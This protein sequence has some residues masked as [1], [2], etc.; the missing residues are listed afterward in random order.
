MEIGQ[1]LRAT[2]EETVD[3]RTGDVTFD[4]PVTGEVEAGR[5]S[6]TLYLRG[7]L[8][9]TAP[10]VC[11]RCLGGF[12]QTLAISVDEEFQIGGAPTGGR[13][14]LGPEDFVVPLGPDL[15]LDVTEVARQHLL[16]ALPMVRVC[17]PEW[18]GLCPVCGE[19]FEERVGGCGRGDGG[20]RRSTLRLWHSSDQMSSCTVHRT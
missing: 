12:R 4:A 19:N 15:V 13:G 18:R 16:L 14:A 17:R 11:G 10:M 9:T 2:F 5:T 20:P 8:T 3:S 7:R 6:G 1:V